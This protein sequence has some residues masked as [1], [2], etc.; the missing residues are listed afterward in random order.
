METKPWQRQSRHFPTQTYIDVVVQKLLRKKTQHNLRHR[1]ASHRGRREDIGSARSG[2]G[3]A[4]GGGGARG[5]GGGARSG[6]GG[7]RGG[8]GGARGG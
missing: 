3:G 4:F 2:G 1:G 7:S 5:G 6:G 8:G